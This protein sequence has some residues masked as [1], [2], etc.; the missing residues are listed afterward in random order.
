[1]KQ[2][3]HNEKGGKNGIFCKE[4]EWLKKLNKINV[5]SVTILSLLKNG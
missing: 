5:T 4:K 3:S 1:M 2:K